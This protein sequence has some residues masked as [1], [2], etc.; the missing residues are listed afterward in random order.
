MKNKER[1][2][3]LLPRIIT[4]RIEINS[5]VL[6]NKTCLLSLRCK[7]RKIIKGN[8][9]II[10]ELLIF[11]LLATPVKLA[12]EEKNSIKV[13]APSINKEIEKTTQSVTKGLF[14]FLKISKQIKKI[15]IR[16][17]ILYKL[18]TPSILLL[19]IKTENIR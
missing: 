15:I 13:Y 17:M 19:D 6:K 5:T 12:E 3:S 18:T 1:T 4:P 11:A 8:F 14:I 2:P 10:E 9:M 7:L 16:I